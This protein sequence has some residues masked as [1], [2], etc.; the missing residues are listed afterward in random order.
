MVRIALI[1]DRSDSVLA[2]R[3]ID[4]CFRMFPDVE[5][6][7]LH[8]TAIGDLSECKGIWCVPASPYADT[9]AALAAIRFARENEVPFLGSCGGFQHAI[10]EYARNALG[11]SAA[12]HAENNPLASMPVIA[13]LECALVEKSGEIRLSQGLIQAAYSGT[14]RIE[15]GYHCSYGFNPAYVDTLF[16]NGRLRA[17]AHDLDGAIRGVELDAHPFFVATLFQSERRALRGELPPLVNA[18]VAAARSA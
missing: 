9:E 4:A 16:G 11:L 8:T 17:T 7:W 10:V 1:G 13:P 15:E 3:A 18:F 12:D 5:A 2:H 6:D 14:E